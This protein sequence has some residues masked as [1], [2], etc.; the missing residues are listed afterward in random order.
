M[1]TNHWDEGDWI[2]NIRMFNDAFNLLCNTLRPHI[3][4]EDTRF[5]I[6][7]YQLKLNLR[8]HCIIEWSVL[9]STHSL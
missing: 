5:L 8:Q 7:A 3:S 6:D 9:N 4:K 2:K 1:M